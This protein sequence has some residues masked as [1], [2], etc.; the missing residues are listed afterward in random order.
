MTIRAGIRTLG[1]AGTALA[2]SL[3]PFSGSTQESGRFANALALDPLEWQLGSYDLRLGAFAA[4]ALFASAQEGGPGFAGGYERNGASALATGNIRIQRT[5][6]NGL[7]LGARSDLLLYRD[8]LS[9]DPYDNDTVQKAYIFLQTGFG[10]VE[11]GQQDGAAYTLGLTGP[12]V[13][14][15]VTLENRNIS[16]YRD[17]TTG[18]DFG[19]F[20][21]QVTAVQSSSNY[22]KINYVSPRLFGVQIGASFTP[23]TVRSAL[24]FTGN[25]SD[26]P[27][28]QHSIW[29][30]AASYT[31][32][33]RGVAV[34]FSGGFA[35]GRLKNRSDGY[36]N[37][38]D[39]SVGTQLAYTI[40]ATTLSFGTAYRGSNAYLLDVEQ[41]MSDSRSRMVQVSASIERPLWLAG[42]EF[43]FANIDGLVGY[44]IKGFQVSAGY[45]INTNMQLSIGWQRYNYSRDAGLFYNGLAEI[46]MD[47]AF[48]ALG[49]TL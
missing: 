45:K 13:D 34:G 6:D 29:E 8:R 2:L 10:R 35:H 12:L 40:E 22:A 15:Q 3:Y 49:Y 16:L 27:N 18:E 36:E 41:V 42:A 31:G 39:W 5:F 46:G 48:L 30:I 11:F 17:P 44:E 47:G 7:V 37:L 28:Q 33:V 4:G 32:N 24:P 23:Q 38:Y 43:S 14:Q 21:R 20:F 1:A 26:D 25:P 19:V 9:T